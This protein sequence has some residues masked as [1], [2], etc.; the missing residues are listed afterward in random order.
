MQL[1][2][3]TPSQPPRRSMSGLKFNSDVRARL[4]FDC[5][6]TAESDA[7]L[8]LFLSGRNMILFRAINNSPNHRRH[9]FLRSSVI[10]GYWSETR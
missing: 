8:T 2:Q 10:I 7:S 5:Y 3:R 1:D 9:H 4:S 6:Q